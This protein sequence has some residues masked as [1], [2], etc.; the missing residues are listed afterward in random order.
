MGGGKISASTLDN[1]YKRK[2]VNPK[3]KTVQ[4]I[5]LWLEKMG[6]KFNENSSEVSG[7]VSSEAKE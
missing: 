5:K 1:F 6:G 4:L 2:T 7:E 3:A